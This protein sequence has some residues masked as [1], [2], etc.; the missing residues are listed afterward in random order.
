MMWVK[1]PIF[2]LLSESSTQA[3]LICSYLSSD[4]FFITSPIFLLC[5]S[6]TL[7]PFTH[8]IGCFPAIRHHYDV[9]QHVLTHQFPHVQPMVLYPILSLLGHWVLLIFQVLFVDF[10][11][12][13]MNTTVSIKWNNFLLLLLGWEMLGWMKHKL[14]S[15]LP[16]EI[17]ITLDRQMTPPLWQ[18]VKRN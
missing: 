12:H 15:R 9:G 11:P 7:E 17:S 13:L 3:L 8:I 10:Y 6:F 4:L 2:P 16:R 1:G 18:K 14:E 5:H